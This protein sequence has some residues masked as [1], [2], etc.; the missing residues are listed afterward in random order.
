[1][2]A[3]Q[4]LVNRNWQG[5]HA[6][7]AY[8]ISHAKEAVDRQPGNAQ[9]RHWLNVYRWQAI[10][11]NRD[12]ETGEIVLPVE[13]LGY[14]ERIVEE[15]N[16]VRTLCPT[17]GATW[18]VLGQL[19]RSVLG[20][21]EEGARH[22]RAGVLLAPCD[23]T[24]RFVAGV[25]AL[26]EDQVEAGLG[27]LARAAQL[28]GRRFRDI[29]SL[30]IDEFDQPEAA[31][32]MAGEDVYRVNTIADVLETSGSNTEA[33]AA[34]RQ[35]IVILLEQ[36]C[37]NPMAS[38][39]TF[40]WLARIHRQEGRAAEAIRYYD[41]ALARDHGRVDWRFELAQLLAETGSVK[42]AVKEA[43]SC[44]RM[45]PEHTAAQQL[46]ERLLLDQRLAEQH[47]KLR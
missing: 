40:A 2:A 32:D 18:C 43:E 19:E 36:R 34:V 47:G 23:P 16:L 12:S 30:L 45:Q 25:L 9:Y 38:A 44:L 33:V 22:I 28:D 29:A 8:L 39:S 31:L 1:M 7:Y 3:E 24:T 13:A 17:F 15:L 14:A 20:R 5:S 37:Q 35:K 27:H 46:I 6:E 10:S 11:N 41:Q 21:E 26:E 4:N 42:K